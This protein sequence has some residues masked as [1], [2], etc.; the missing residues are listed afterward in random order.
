MG[1]IWRGYE[2][3]MGRIGQLYGTDMGAIWEKVA[4]NG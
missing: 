2:D 1:G 3:G 4:G